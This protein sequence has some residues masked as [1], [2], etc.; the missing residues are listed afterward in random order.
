MKAW[1]IAG[2]SLTIGARTL[3]MGIL[4][5]TPDSF[6]DGGRWATTDAAAVRA[7]EMLGEGADIID[8]GGEST[9]PGSAPVAIDEELRRV[10]PVIERLAV[11]HAAVISVDTTR[12][13]VARLA[14]AAGAHIVNDISGLRFEPE[15]ADHV[16]ASSAGL[17]LMHSL[18]ARETL[19]SAAPVADIFAGVAADW[20]R[21][22][23]EA[24]RRGVNRAQIALDPGFGFGKTHNQNLE[25]LANLDQLVEEFSEYPMLVG[26][27]RKRFIGRV[28]ADAAGDD[29]PI[30]ARLHGTT[31]SVVAAVLGGADIVRVHDVR[32]CAEA[33]RVA[34]AVRAVRKLI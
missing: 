7:R 20:R 31:A 27:S 5:A 4:N 19:H 2:G 34:N 16:A 15:I 14:F 18:G 30:E 11:E 24:E 6:S 3:V 9:R 1:H 23:A 8:I 29:A 33:A 13:E 22:I 32:A 21:G 12:A 10:I 17:I 26:T 28:L 25:L